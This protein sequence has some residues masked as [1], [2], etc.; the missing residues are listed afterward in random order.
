MFCQPSLES[1]VRCLPIMRF[2]Y[3][4]CENVD[5]PAD[6]AEEDVFGMIV[7]MAN[8]RRCVHSGIDFLQSTDRQQ[9]SVRNNIP[10]AS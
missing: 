9:C 3:R 10:L 8:W 2:Q 6:D 1:Y 4:I 5:R 7:R